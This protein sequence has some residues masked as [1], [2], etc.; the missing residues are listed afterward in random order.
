MCALITALSFFFLLIPAL[1]SAQLTVVSVDSEVMPAY[2]GALAVD[3]KLDTFWHTVWAPNPAPLP[4]QI[5]LDLQRSSFVIGL[6]YLPR[7]DGSLNGTITEHEIYVSLDGTTWGTPVATGLWAGDKA[8]KETRFA[9]VQGRYVKLVALKEAFEQPYTSAAELDPIISLDGPPPVIPQ[10]KV[11]LAW[12]DNADNE[13]GF[14]VEQQQEGF[15]WRLAEVLN[16]DAARVTVMAP[17]NVESNFRVRAFNQAGPSA[18]TNTV[19]GTPT[20]PYIS[21]PP[22]DTPKPALAP[23][24]T[25]SIPAG[26][27]R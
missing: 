18:Y 6:R 3:G 22:A 8:Q 15:P 16:Q 1:T 26:Q 19:T 24:F 2:A 21:N 10:G 17:L 23:C 20:V 12:T 11:T 14:E 7:Q 13:C 25:V 4:H 27:S 5:I 9:A